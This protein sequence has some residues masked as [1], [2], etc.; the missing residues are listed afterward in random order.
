MA[1]KIFLGILVLLIIIQLFRPEP[2]VSN[3]RT[4]D[5]STRYA[6]PEDVQQVLAVACNDCHTNQTTYPWYAQVQPVA[7]WL[8]DHVTDGKRHLNLSDF[9]KAPLAIQYHK[10]EEIVEVVEEREMP[11]KEYTY[12]GLHPEANLTDDQRQ[13]LIQ[14]AKAQMDTLKANYPA[15]SLVRKPRKS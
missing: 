12:L 6:V 7:W 5:I 4:N 15:D 8:N 11:M 9:T 14:W 2:N 1:G 10:L 3:D 13:L